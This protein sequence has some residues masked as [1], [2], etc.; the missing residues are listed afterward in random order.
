MWQNCRQQVLKWFKAVFGAESGFTNKQRIRYL[1]QATAIT[2]F[3]GLFFYRSL[4][5]V[6]LMLPVGAFYLINAEGIKRKERKRCLRSEFKDAIL[7]ISANIR[8]GYAVENA[9]R[10]TLS[11]MKVLYGKDSPV[12][13]ELYKIVQGMANNLSIEYLME[14]FARRAEL[15]EIQEFADIFSIA[16]RSGGNLTEIIGETAGIISEKIEAEKEIQ[17][18]LA[19]KRLEWNIMAVVPFAII[20]Y[21]SV[22]SEGYFDVLYTS[23]T[24][25]TVMTVCLAVYITA[26]FSGVNI[27]EVSV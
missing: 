22:A 21:V 20:L 18:L 23:F 4:W 24:G 19:A 15:E 12:F 7:T 3:F 13:Q 25:R 5:A 2:I 17:T 16:K 14:Q 27:V 6:P 8:A 1:L 9:F 10:E 11:E 26:Y